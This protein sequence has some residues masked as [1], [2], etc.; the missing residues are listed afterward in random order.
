MPSENI[1]RQHKRHP[2]FSIGLL[3][4][5]IQSVTPFI[6]LF[7]PAVVCVAFV[8][9]DGGKISAETPPTAVSA[10]SVKLPES[11]NSI[12]M[13]FNLIP[14]GTILNGGK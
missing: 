8:A 6:Q 13:K 3:T 9:A 2:R 4:P 1:L 12:G 10:G 14:A 5:F 7:K 11:I